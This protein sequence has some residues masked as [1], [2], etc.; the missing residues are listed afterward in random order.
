M[1]MTYTADDIKRIEIGKDTFAIKLLSSNGA[2]LGVM[3]HVN[4]M[5]VFEPSRFRKDMLRIK[6][7]G[8][9]D[10]ESQWRY[11]RNYCLKKVNR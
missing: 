1:E 11:I 7:P 10:R 9:G 8:L 5:A 6:T 4:G 3:E 2:T